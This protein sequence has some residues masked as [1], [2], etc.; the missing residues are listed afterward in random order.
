MREA[1]EDGVS[2][3]LTTEPLPSSPP[4]PP[5]ARVGALVVFEGLVRS[6]NEGKRVLR[7]EYSAY[8]ALAQSEGETILREAAEQ[9]GMLRADCIHRLGVL[10]VGDCAVKVWALGEHR[11]EAFAACAYIMDQ[12]KRRVPIW[13]RETYDDGECRWVACHEDHAMNNP[14]T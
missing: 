14:P 3:R 1:D 9:F 5:T 11:R 10:A 2:F 12:L 7:L 13:K 6:H 4:F 8:T